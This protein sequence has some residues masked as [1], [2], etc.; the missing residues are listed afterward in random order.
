MNIIE[1][2]ELCCVERK[3]QQINSKSSLNQIDDFPI[4]MSYTPWQQFSK[5]Y[6]HEEALCKGTLFPEL[7]KP[8]MK[9]RVIYN[10]R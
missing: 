1:D 8:F 6:S 2:L 10:D 3:P 4:A 7:D 9:G 5:T